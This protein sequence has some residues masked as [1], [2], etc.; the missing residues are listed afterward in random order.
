M[1]L[2]PLL[3]EGATLSKD[4]LCSIDIDHSKFALRLVQVANATETSAFPRVL[5]IVNTISVHH[6]VHVQAIRDT[7]GQRCTK[8][9][10]FSNATDASTPD[11]IEVDA[12]A[13][14]HHLW[15]KHKLTLRYVWEHY[16]HEFDWFYKADD[17][18]YIVMEN[19]R[20]FLR[21][22]EVLMQQDVVPLSF[23]HRY[24]LTPDLIDYY[25]VDKNLLASFKARTERWVFNSGG[26]GYAMNKLYVQAV[27]ES[28]DD[29]TCLSGPATSMLPD[30]ASISFC[31]VF[32]DTYPYNTR[33]LRGRERW[34]ADKPRGV[35]F[36]DVSRPDYWLVRYHDGIGGARR[37]ADCCSPESVAFHYI[38]PPLMYHLERQLYYCRST[39]PDLA[40]FNAA[41]GLAI[42]DRILAPETLAIDFGPVPDLQ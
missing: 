25:I 6:D 29:V 18:A 1:C 31:M 13:D 27:V 3:V 2:A 12:I 40:S 9:L 41:H 30:D 15:Q 22:P 28:L 7:W 5:C 33:D 10:F 21:Q 37:H 8:L 26:P 16:R 19:L 11:I 24:S 20:A 35:F 32:H 23:G 34:H 42:S 38:L 17:D 36:E 4:E 39:A 14:H